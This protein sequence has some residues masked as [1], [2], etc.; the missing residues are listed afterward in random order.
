[1]LFPLALFGAAWGG[2]VMAQALFPLRRI[3]AIALMCGAGAVLLLLQQNTLAANLTMHSDPLLLSGVILCLMAPA[4]VA[5]LT[6]GEATPRS[7][8]AL[9]L[10]TIPLLSAAKVSVGFVWTALVCYWALRR[11][12]LMRPGFWIVVLLAAALF[13]PGYFLFADPHGAGAVLFG[14]PFFAE[15]F[16][17]GRYFDPI[18]MHLQALVTI[19]WLLCLREIAPAPRR[20]LLE[21]LAIAILVGMLPGL[22]MDIPGHDAYYFMVVVAWVSVPP[23]LALLGDLPSRLGAATA[24]RRRIGWG[25]VAAVTVLITVLG[26]K[27]LPLKFNIVMANNALLRTGDRSYY[28]EDNRRGWREDGRR[29]QKELGVLG[30]FH[31]TPPAPQGQSLVEALRSFKAEIGNT[32]AAYLEPQS[33]YWPLVSDCDGKATYPMSMAG[34]PVIDGYLP[35]QDTCP[36]QFSLRGY[37]PPPAVRSALNDADLCAR[38]K[39]EGFTTM[40]RISSL[41]DRTTDRR[42][43]CR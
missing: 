33:D 6:T 14:T 19:V 22:L 1:V 37:A 26:A 27:A 15:S 16:D 11:L 20:L 13:I 42:L 32:G 25:A 34:V 40:L 43:D 41:G 35:V 23:M 28:D 2:L 9:A 31:L 30:M 8:W 10:V 5:M 24:L 38:A 29:A 39:Q 12:G 17:E 36:Q 18:L 21:A 3:S 4:V 7:A